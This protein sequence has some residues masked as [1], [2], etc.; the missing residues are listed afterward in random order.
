MKHAGSLGSTKEA[1]EFLKAQPNFRIFS[2]NILAVLEKK[3]IEAF[4]DGR[5]LDEIALWYTRHNSWESRMESCAYT[6]ENGTV[7]YFS[8]KVRPQAR[9]Q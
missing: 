7:G 8:L 3:G 5:T 1:Q 4:R 6:I 9:R 2:S